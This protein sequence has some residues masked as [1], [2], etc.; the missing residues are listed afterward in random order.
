MYGLNKSAQYID[1]N[2]GFSGIRGVKWFLGSLEFL[3]GSSGL[4][5]IA[6]RFFWVLWGFRG[7]LGVLHVLCGY[8]EFLRSSS[9]FCS[10]ST[11]FL[12]RVHWWVGFF[13]FFQ[14][15]W[16]PHLK[17]SFK[18]YTEVKAFDALGH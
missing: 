15:F 16:G 7:S 18:F 11:G 8:L 4:C 1:H 9:G 10:S 14:A 13:W 2:V 6:Q 5:S 17:P 12:F 3:R